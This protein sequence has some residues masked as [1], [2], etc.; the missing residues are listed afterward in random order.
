MNII[1]SPLLAFQGSLPLKSCSSCWE[2]ELQATIPTCSPFY[3][4]QRSFIPRTKSQHHIST[5]MGPQHCLLVNKCWA[6][7]DRRSAHMGLWIKHVALIKNNLAQ[8][9]QRPLRSINTLPPSP[10]HP[11]HTH[12]SPPSHRVQGERSLISTGNIQRTHSNSV[13]SCGDWTLNM[14]SG[15]K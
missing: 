12:Q 3:H 11:T 6:C 2:Y 13:W 1:M 7:L 4:L 15:I 5:R 10:T 14:F 9:Y 8:K